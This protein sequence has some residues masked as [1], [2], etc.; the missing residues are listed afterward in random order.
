VQRLVGQATGREAEVDRA[1]KETEEVIA[2]QA[3][4]VKQFANRTVTV[5]YQFFDQFLINGADIS[6]S[7]LVIQLGLTIKS[8]DQ[9]KISELSLEQIRM[10][11]DADILL[12]PEFFAKDM[13]QLEANPLFKT[14]PAAQN[15]RYVRLSVEVARASYLESA[16]SVRWVVP[17]IA[18]AIIAAAEGRGKKLAQ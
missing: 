13:D 17:Q 8:P 3:A 5:A 10:V 14:L 16:L 6:I 15:G 7:R 12:S 9:T 11:E 18:D 2:S 4:R 1:I